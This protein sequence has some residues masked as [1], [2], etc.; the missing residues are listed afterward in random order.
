MEADACQCRSKEK[1]NGV[2]AGA[3]DLSEEEKAGEVFSQVG[4]GPD[5]GWLTAWWIG[6]ARGRTR[7]PGAVTRD[8]EAGNAPEGQAVRQ[9]TKEKE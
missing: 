2:C 8:E 3:V 7:A 4:A 1:G 6:L 5:V 9:R